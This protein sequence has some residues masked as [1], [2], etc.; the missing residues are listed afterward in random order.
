LTWDEVGFS[1]DPGAFTIFTVPERVE[2]HGDPMATMLEQRP[3]VAGA[4]GE[5][6]K[7]L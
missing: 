4:V 6:G 7:L 5:L 2:R 3:D 1:L